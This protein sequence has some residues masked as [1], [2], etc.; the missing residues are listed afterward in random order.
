FLS[1]AGVAFISGGAI[2]TIGGNLNAQFLGTPRILFAM[3][4]QE[5][6]P[7]VL[8]RIH[9]RFRTPYVAILFTAGVQLL[10]AV[11]SGFTYLATLSVITRILGYSTA[12]AALP[13]LRHREAPPA[14]VRIPMGPAISFVAL[15]ACAWLLSSSTVAEARDTAA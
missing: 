13:I 1:G 9:P 10:L 7:S 4:E 14:R 12:I 15:L 2:V 6:V 11:S 8:G 5:Q 3:A